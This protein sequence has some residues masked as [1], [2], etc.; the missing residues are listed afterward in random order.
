[1][2]IKPGEYVNVLAEEVLNQKWRRSKDDPEGVFEILLH[3]HRD[4]SYTHLLRVRKGV[5]F[6]EPVKHDYFEEVYYVRGEMLNTK[7]RE[8]VRAG[9][10]VLHKPHE[11][12]GPFKCLKECLIL[13]FRYYK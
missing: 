3:K 11:P 9:M 4:G 13:E 12:H 2:P 10:Y 7:T 5:V 8:K 1:M 6:P